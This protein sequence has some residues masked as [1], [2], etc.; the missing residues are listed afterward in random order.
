MDFL[1]NSKTAKFIRDKNWK[2]HPL[3]QPHGS[4]V[5]LKF[6]SRVD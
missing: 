1:N 5:E 3:G 4:A 6:T 2:K